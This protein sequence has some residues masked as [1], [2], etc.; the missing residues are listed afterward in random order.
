MA[1]SSD[2]EK[3]IVSLIQSCQEQVKYTYGYRRIK[4]WILRET[5]LI[6]NH[7]AILRI[8]NKYSLVARIRRNKRYRSFLSD[9]IKYENKLKRRFETDKLNTLWSTDITQFYAKDGIVYVSAVKDL[10]DGYIVS[11]R[12]GKSNNTA[13]VMETIEMARTSEQIKND[14]SL[15]IHSDQGCQ[16]TSYEYNKYLRDHSITP[17]MSRPGRPIDN[18]PIENFFGTMKTEWFDFDTTKYTS[19]EIRQLVIDY[20]EF[21]NNIRIRT[22]IGM[23]PAEKRA[24]AG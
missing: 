7:K 13:L 8:T 22:K 2:W 19:Y 16:Y 6:V 11:Y 12:I 10:C 21:Y 20:I 17:S 14:G 23:P 5:G 15:L 9:S 4:I 18:A 3:T 24:A 1:K